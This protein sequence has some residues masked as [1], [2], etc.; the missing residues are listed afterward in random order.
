MTVSP[1]S[2][3]R[4]PSLDVRYPLIVVDW[5]LD[6]H[7]YDSGFLRLVGPSDLPELTQTPTLQMWDGNGRPVTVHGSA[8]TMTTTAT[9]PAARNILLQWRSRLPLPIMPGSMSGDTAIPFLVDD[10]VAAR[11]R[12]TPTGATRRPGVWLRLLPVLLMLVSAAAII[13]LVRNDLL[14]GAIAFI[15]YVASA[16]LMHRWT[17]PASHWGH[18]TS[19]D[20]HDWV[21]RAALGAKVVFWAVAAAAVTLALLDWAE[22]AP[23]LLSW[24]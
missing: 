3:S 1:P 8:V 5:A 4:T 9:D 19:R 24:V 12:L 2:M 16:S 18:R 21:S 20:P 7:R 11:N 23:D 22:I 10:V 6:R 15:G 17:Y 14:N 13:P